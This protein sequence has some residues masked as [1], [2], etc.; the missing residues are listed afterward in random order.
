M[1][2][3]LHDMRPAALNPPEA[4][5][6]PAAAASASY[7]L[8]GVVRTGSIELDRIKPYSSFTPVTARCAAVQQARGSLERGPTLT[9]VSTKHQ[10]AGNGTSVQQS[11]AVSANDIS[12]QVRH[13]IS[14][15]T[16]AVSSGTTPK[17][18][19]NEEPRTRAASARGTPASHD[20]P[21]EGARRNTR[22]S[23]EL[24]RDSVAPRGSQSPQG[25]ECGTPERLRRWASCLGASGSG[26]TSGEAAAP[27]LPPVHVHVVVLVHG[28][29]GSA[30]DLR[31]I[32]NH[33][34]VMAPGAICLMCKSNEG[35]T[36]DGFEA[37]G[38][39]VAGEVA[40]FLQRLQTP[41]PAKGRPRKV[42]EKLTFIGHSIGNLTIRAALTEAEM[43]PFLPQLWLFLSI[44]GPHLGYLCSSNRLF[45]SGLWLLKSFQQGC[46]LQQLSFNDAPLLRDCFLYKLAQHSGLALFRWVVLVA[47]PQ[48]QYVPLP[49]AR[50]QHLP[51]SYGRSEPGADARSADVSPL[52][53]C[54]PTSDLGGRGLDRSHRLGGAMVGSQSSGN[55]SSLAAGFH[56][57]H[58]HQDVAVRGKREQVYA[59]MLDALV[60]DVEKARGTQLLRVDVD[61]PL[62]RWHSISNA[63]GRTAHIE[64]IETDVYTRFLLWAVLRRR[65]LL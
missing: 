39:R 30:T 3:K 52:A 11:S 57:A 9:E 29:Q 50:V 46:T 6:T 34:Q 28:F 7:P 31:L 63:V 13:E 44:S 12:V 18:Q 53:S 26:R 23:R 8:G 40:A 33:I 35:L 22:P 47:S 1:H 51:I 48:D 43:Q 15:V 10:T 61:F 42:L 4:S 55:L 49:S 24:A 37:M 32:R 19:S 58:L 45:C 5:S 54:L 20:L 62:K 25:S 65:Q 2:A 38:R 56:E 17:R 60:V 16:P 59:E 36:L 64:F 21:R 27:E 14:S 41:V